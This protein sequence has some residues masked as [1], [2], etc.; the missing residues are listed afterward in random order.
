MSSS[1][2]PSI[3]QANGLI[4]IACVALMGTALYMEYGV[5]L[6]PCPLCITQRGFVLLTGLWAL[7]ALLHHPGRIGRRVYGGLGALS[8]ALGAAVA[9]RQLYL[10]SLP[11]DQVPACGPSLG[12]ILDVF[13]LTEAISVLLRGDGA[14]A[15]VSWT[16]LGISIP[17]WTLAAF[18]LLIAV[19]LWQ[20]L[21]RAPLP[22][23]PDNR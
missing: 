5:G 8:A 7:L 1:I 19:N 16:F 10:Q 14:C 12:Y 11:P 6:E 3:R 13:P 15:E 17:G 2:F 18:V 22:T 20:I 23:I 4:L 21:R 9:M